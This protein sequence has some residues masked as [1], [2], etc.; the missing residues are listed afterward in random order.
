MA[1][2]CCHTGRAKTEAIH[3]VRWEVPLAKVSN[4]KAAVKR[5]RIHNF[6]G[7]PFS[8]VFQQPGHYPEDQWRIRNSATYGIPELSK[9]TA[10]VVNAL[11]NLGIDIQRNYSGS[12]M[13]ADCY[14]MRAEFLDGG[15]ASMT[16]N[17]WYYERG[18][19]ITGSKVGLLLSLQLGLKVRPAWR[20]KYGLE[21]ATLESL[22]GEMGQE[23]GEQES[24]GE[25]V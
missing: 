22:K 10:A 3:H 8:A 25:T 7:Q 2:W 24:S 23:V 17:Y 21:E 14:R 5:A 19:Y 12:P 4:K 11:N 1:R 18:A 20:R 6:S 15:V 13:N 9:Q 16:G